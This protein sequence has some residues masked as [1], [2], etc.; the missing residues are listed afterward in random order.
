MSGNLIEQ[1]QHKWETRKLTKLT[2]TAVAAA[3]TTSTSTTKTIAMELT[4]EFG[5]FIILF[6]SMS[7]WTIVSRSYCAKKCNWLNGFFFFDVHISL[8]KEGK[9]CENNAMIFFICLW[10]KFDCKKI[11]FSMRIKWLAG[12]I[13]GFSIVLRVPKCNRVSNVCRSNGLIDLI[14]TFWKF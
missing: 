2:T 3:T 1:Q 7:H 9:M 14:Q 8:Y 10:D 11:F 13:V 5:K 12:S 6:C 4:Y